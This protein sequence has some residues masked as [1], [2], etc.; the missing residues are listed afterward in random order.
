MSSDYRLAPAVIVRM[1]GV[2]LTLVGVLVLL[3]VL[4]GA[5]LGWPAA[6]LTTT[7][8][9]AAV[10]VV[11]TLVGGLLL[12]R[13]ATVVRLDETGYR[14]RWVRGAGVTEGPWRDV[15]DAVATTIR[16][17]RCVVVR[18]RDGGATTI[19]VDI[20]AAPADDFVRDLQQHLNRGHGYRPVQ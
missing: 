6:V 14:V 8:L 9:V 15:E 16:G 2:V 13:R 20:I 3:V 4:V 7:L 11:A 18:R 5:A 1:A 10:A 19:P 17:A 12:A